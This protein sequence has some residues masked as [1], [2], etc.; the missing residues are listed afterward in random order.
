MV[1]FWWSFLHIFF[2]TYQCSFFFTYLSLVFLKGKL[3]LLRII[4]II[5]SHLLFSTSVKVY[6]GIAG[7]Y[8]AFCHLMIIYIDLT[9]NS[10]CHKLKTVE[11]TNGDDKLIIFMWFIQ[12]KQSWH[13]MA[14]PLKSYTVVSKIQDLMNVFHSFAFA[15]CSWDQITNNRWRGICEIQSSF[16]I[17]LS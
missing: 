4:F 3:S 13:I 7:Y 12:F 10:N 15:F 1:I 5:L 17:F 6:Q 11:Y 9:W 2:F 16:G 8:R 14:G